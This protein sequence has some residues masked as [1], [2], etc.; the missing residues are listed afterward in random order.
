M[1]SGRIL[2]KELSCHF[3]LREIVNASTAAA[4]GGLREFHQFHA[5][6]GPEDFPRLTGDF[7]SVAKMAGTRGR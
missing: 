5:G 2:Q 7:L 1:N 4:P 3:R 6:N